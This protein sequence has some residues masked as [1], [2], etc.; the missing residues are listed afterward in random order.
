MPFLLQPSQFILAWDR[1]QICWLAYRVSGLRWRWCRCTHWLLRYVGV[2]QCE[3]LLNAFSSVISTHSLHQLT[4]YWQSSEEGMG[5]LYASHWESEQRNWLRTTDVDYRLCMVSWWRRSATGRALDLRSVGHGFKSYSRQRC[6]KC[7]NLRQ[8]VHTY[9][10]LSPSSITWYRPKGGVALRLGGNRQAWQKVMT[11]YR[12]V[13][14]LRSPA[15]LLPVHRDHLWAQR[16]VSSM[17]S[18]YLYLLPFTF[19]N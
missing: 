14:D 19:Q 7:S 15:G 17:G 9:V 10:P 2:A 16:S 11:A 13:D 3:E 1:H 4:W 12:R 18:L 8:V 6:I 5:I